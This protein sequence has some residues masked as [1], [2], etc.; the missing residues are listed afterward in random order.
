MVSEQEPAYKVIFVR[1]GQSTWNKANRFIGWTD[2]N[3]TK[4]G[5]LEARVAGQVLLAA[6]YEFDIIY[7]SLL[8][9]SI[10]TAWVVMDELGL[11]HVPVVT[12]WRLNERC[13]GAL[14]G[15]NK[16]ECVRVYGEDQV[17]LWRRSF[18]VRPPPI[19]EDSSL[20]P[21]NN[22]KYDF[23]ERALIPRTE[24]LQD[25]QARS[26]DCWDNTI[27]PTIRSGKRVCVCGHENNLRSLLK[28]LDGVSDD[29]IRHVELP[30]AVP[31]IYHL[32]E[33]FKPIRLEGA[34]PHLN[35]RYIGDAEEIAAIMARDLANV[36]DLSV[37]SN[38]EESDVPHYAA[39]LDDL[40]QPCE[41][42]D[43]AFGER[44]GLDELNCR[45]SDIEETPLF[46]YKSHEDAAR[47]RV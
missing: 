11:H 47:A 16:K 43:D 25:T 46:I 44:G 10:K 8:K 5:E 3:L 24:S 23:L 21:G 18:D 35:G 26:V 32:D 17:K 19:S 42:T 29:D 38:L 7:T 39:K 40:L 9:R 30:R 28:H 37:E 1:H 27:V 36:Y 22:R 2:P 20:W 41:L 6:G 33:N 34:A 4:T 12:D 31:L 45:E 15:R 13:Y 14:V